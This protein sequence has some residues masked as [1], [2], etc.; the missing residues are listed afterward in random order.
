[1]QL[2]AAIVRREI[3]PGAP[4]VIEQLA[5]ALGV[6]RTPIREA[7]PALQQLGLIV[8]SA[9]SSYR[10]A[11]LDADYAREVYAVRSALECLL[12]EEVTPL[13]T[14]DDLHRLRQLALRTPN[15]GSQ[16]PEAGPLPDIE[17]HDV[18][19]ARCPLPFLNVLIDS[20]RVHR[21]RLLEF[22]P[23]DDAG[24]QQKSQEEHLAIVEALEQRNG[25]AARRLMRA[26]LD[27]VGANM[28]RLALHQPPK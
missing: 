17:F 21:A 28:A 13:L 19:R 22:E 11:P 27:R 23:V 25:P 14:E 20:V 5:E 18:L 16:E 6:S 4:V 26:H 10:V 7:L 1:M 9:T 12:V 24:R 15:A 8:E 2:R 3:A